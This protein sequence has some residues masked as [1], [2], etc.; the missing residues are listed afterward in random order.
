M[1]RAELLE[2][3]H[4]GRQQLEAILAQISDDH[5]TTP[6]LPGQWSA[7]DLLAHIGWWE[8]RIVTTYHTL[9]RGETPDPEADALPVD[10]LNA[11]VYALYCDRPLAEV[12]REEHEAYYAL[13]VLAESA[14]EDDL[15]NQ[16]R[17]AWTEEQA[18]CEWISGNTYEHY[19]EHL[20]DLRALLS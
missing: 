3:I 15:F 13:L 14:P 20:R 1:K 4:T 19:E 6:S 5:M 17:F 11:H 12:R 9:L 10:E 7:K 16:H 2:R 8:Q 18:F